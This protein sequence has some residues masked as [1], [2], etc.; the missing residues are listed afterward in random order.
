MTNTPDFE[1]AIEDVRRA[2]RIVWAYQRRV[3]DV[4]EAITTEFPETRHYWW[5]TNSFDCLPA[6]KTTDPLG[7]WA[8]DGLPLYNFSILRLSEDGPDRY[9]PKL[10]RWMLEISH[11]ADH[12]WD[13]E[14]SGEPDASR[15]PQVD[16]VVSSLSVCLWRC[17]ANTGQEWW[18]GAWNDIEGWLG[19]GEI[20]QHADPFSD[21]ATGLT[22]IGITRNV[23]D[24]KTA[25]DASSLAND[26]RRLGRE[27]L[28]L[29]L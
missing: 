2:Y 20:G 18:A 28:Q 1:A 26:L 23:A 25:E 3:L 5:Q 8:W 22:G 29:Q 9:L 13:E 11:N 24:I 21:E 19:D 12:G 7:R 16:T 27:V 17:D 4:I 6:R 14:A 15:F 10:G